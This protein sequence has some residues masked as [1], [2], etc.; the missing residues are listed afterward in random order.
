MNEPALSNEEA[1]PIPTGRAYVALA[2]VSC[3]TLM[4]EIVL[5]R[6]FSVTMWYHYAFLAISLA[7]FGMTIGALVVW[8]LP[9]GGVFGGLAK[10]SLCFSVSILLSFFYHAYLPT[11]PLIASNPVQKAI[12]L[13]LMYL[14]FSVPFIFSGMCMCIALTRFPSRVGRLYAADLL[15]A[16]LG[17]LLVIYILDGTDGPTT[18]VF[19]ALLAGAGAMFFSLVT[20]RQKLISGVAVYCLVL[21]VFFGLCAFLISAYHPLLKLGWVKGTVETDLM[22]QKWNSFS[23]VT[24]SGNPAT[25]GYPAGWALSR[26]YTDRKMG[27]QLNLQI[28]SSAGTV[29]TEYSGKSNQI[30]H[31][32]YDL[33][34]TAHYLRPKAKVLVIG[35]GGGRDVL[36]ALAFEQASVVGVEINGDILNAVNGVFGEFTGQLDALPQVRFVNDEAR[37]YIARSGEKYD[38]IQASLI[39]TC[40]ASAAGAFVLAEHALYTTEAWA[41]F[42]GHLTERGILTF[43]RWYTLNGVL[44]PEVYRTVSLARDALL[45]AGTKDPRQHVVLLKPTGLYRDTVA[46]ILVSRSP[47]TPADLENL[48]RIC[49]ALQWEVLLGP[50]LSQGP[51]WEQLI[52]GQTPAAPGVDPEA[53]DLSAPTDDRPF[54]FWVTKPWHLFDRNLF[55]LAPSAESILVLALIL[56]VALSAACFVFPFLF[57]TRGLKGQP[58]FSLAAFFLSIGCGF[59]FIEVAQMQRLIIFLGHPT[60]GLSVILF[61]LLLSS[62]LGSYWADRLSPGKARPVFILLLVA[63]GLV[64]LLS[65][66]ICRHFE[67][68]PFAMR[69]ALAVG[70]MFPAGFAMGMPFPLGMKCANPRMP[71]A[72]PWLWGLNGAASVCASVVSVLVSLLWGISA[73]YATGF[74]CYVIAGLLFLRMLQQSTMEYPTP[75]T[76]AL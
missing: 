7:M 46:T 55:T 33:V 13:L 1:A 23:R 38:I 70:L 73:A 64:G 30:E 47:F 4:F 20:G 75:R 12:F 21:A 19:S 5:T 48:G 22:Y 32:K 65:P 8:R 66:P 59:M 36:A 15:G 28:D 14:V 54:F 53:I 25:A 3:A 24:V 67:S 68:Q 27:R 45:Q 42:I 29:L 41:N 9:R 37:S 6:I 44:A 49:K 63:V 17:C 10:W 43:S 31:L 39:D 57:V 72:T 11:N 18:V 40:A 61:S 51:I 16:S 71:S 62:G 69:F 76:G 74:G 56:V 35:V 2:L 34:N 58:I 60:Y 52:N 26:A 50:G